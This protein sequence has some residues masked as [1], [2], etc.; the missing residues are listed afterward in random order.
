M[1]EG[2]SI[3]ILKEQ[4]KPFK[5]KK[6]T[7]AKGNTGIDISRL[8]GLRITDFKS[9]GKHLLIC[10]K[11]FFI[12]IHLMMWGSYRINEKKGT[13]ERMSLEFEEGELNFY[14]CSVKLVE[15]DP[16]E[17]YDWKADVMSD[18]WSP[19]KAERKVK[20]QESAIA[21]DV[22]LEQDIF[23]GVGNIIKNEVLF[24]IKIH[25]ESTIGSLPPKKLKELVKEARN[26]SLDFYRWKK[27][28]E[29]KKHFLIYK[30]KKCP[31]CDGQVTRKYLGKHERLTCY[32]SNCQE[33]FSKTPMLSNLKG[34]EKYII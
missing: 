11:N 4:L 17:V 28:F 34:I 3:V 27:V 22:L 23:A 15:A 31:D 19:A 12:R 32:C 13:P 10:F 24:R 5:R 29:L 1:P 25:P 9:W 18:Q 26:Y 30:K 8:P 6:I 7:G 33:L 20:G 2:P 14:N 21:C 16:D